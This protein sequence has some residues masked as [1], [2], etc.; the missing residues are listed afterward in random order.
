MLYDEINGAQ[1]FR[2]FFNSQ[3]SLSR[4]HLRT[5]QTE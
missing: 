4:H 5:H 3:V 2:T 1:L